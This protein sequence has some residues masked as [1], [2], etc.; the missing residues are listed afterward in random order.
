M[1]L[2]KISVVHWNITIDIPIRSEEKLS[3]SIF[4]YFL[5]LQTV[6]LHFDPLSVIKL[7]HVYIIKP[8]TLCCVSTVLARHCSIF[9]STMRLQKILYFSWRC[10]CNLT[11]TEALLRSSFGVPLCSNEVFVGNW[12]RYHGCCTVLFLCSH[13]TDSVLKTQILFIHYFILFSLFLSCKR[14]WTQ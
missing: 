7:M 6:N 12:L 2:F 13:Y 4:L 14:W 5:G 11:A 10:H 8:V 1:L 3:E 9:K